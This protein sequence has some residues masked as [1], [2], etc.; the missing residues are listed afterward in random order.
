MWVRF[1]FL[2]IDRYNIRNNVA[3]KYIQIASA[4]GSMS[5]KNSL[6]AS[7]YKTLDMI[8]IVA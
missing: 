5:F 6:V 7:E 8:I 2:I 4:M 1:S 3:E